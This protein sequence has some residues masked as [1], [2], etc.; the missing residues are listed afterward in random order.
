MPR[1]RDWEWAT[2]RP[3]LGRSVLEVGA[4]MGVLSEQLASAGL[5]RLV[6]ADTE[7][8]FLAHLRDAFGGRQDVEVVEVALPG[9]VDI[10]RPVESA[11]AMNVLEHIEDDVAALR[12]LAAAVRPGGTVVLWVPA[13]MRLYGEFDRKLGHVRRY[14]PTTMRATAERAGL[15][16]RLVRPVNLLGGLAWWA[17]VRRGGVDRPNPRLAALYDSVL[18]PAS[19]ALERIVTPPFGQS[20]LC[21]GQVG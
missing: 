7:E 10:G 8:Y 15:S 20:V 13:Y 1:Y 11:V 18:V 19:R 3:Y 14:T 5:E 17:A 2:V 12:D 6:L 4:G 21:V 16:V 9:P